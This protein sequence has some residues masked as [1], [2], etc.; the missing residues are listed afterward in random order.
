[1][2]SALALLVATV[3]LAATACGGGSDSVPSGAVAV[4]DGTE[5]SKADLDELFDQAKRSYE[6]QKQEFPKAG[7]PE[8]QSR[9]TEY[10]AYLV[11]LEQFRQA[12]AELGIEVTDSEIDKLEQEFIDER[13]QGKREEY[14]KALE[15]QGFTAAKY[16]DNALAVS[17][18]TNELFS[19]VTRGVKVSEQEIAEY[20]AQNQS[21]YGAGSRDVRHILVA[22]KD[23]DGKVDFAASKAKAD[24][25]YAQLI[26]G[27]NFAA[28]AKAES[29]DPGSKAAGGKLTIQRGQTVPEFEKVSFELDKGEISKP[30]KTQYGYHVIEAISAVREATPL[31]D[32]RPAIRA[33]LLSEKRKEFMQTW[34]E[35]LKKKYDGKVSYAVGYAPPQLPEE[36]TETE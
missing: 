26:D 33:Q 28:L 22:E 1:M 12:A 31:D 2:R 24:A 29:Q 32:V 21:Q 23:S 10:V 9:Q 25:I 14:E 27:A 18:L 11:E 7:T 34:V 15:A 35:D 3:A 4:V 17:V 36:P 20:Y 16:R 19:E 6:A 13:F 5:V 30:V 8:Y